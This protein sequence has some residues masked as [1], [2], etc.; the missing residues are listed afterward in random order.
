M[1][2]LGRGKERIHYLSFLNADEY[3]RIE[4]YGS[5][6]RE[7]GQSTHEWVVQE[8]E[9][10]PGHPDVELLTSGRGRDPFKF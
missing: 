6:N 3:H 10:P 2:K 1:F 9:W 4:N 5:Q 7:R 8:R